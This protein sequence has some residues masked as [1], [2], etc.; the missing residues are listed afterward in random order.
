MLI[1][2]ASALKHCFLMYF[3]LQIIKVFGTH[4]LPVKAVP[5]YNQVPA[6]LSFDR[7]NK[8]YALNL[9]VQ[10][11]FIPDQRSTLQFFPKHFPY[12]QYPLQKTLMSHVCTTVIPAFPCFV[13]SCSDLTRNK[14]CLKKKKGG[15][16]RKLNIQQLLR[17]FSGF[18][19]SHSSSK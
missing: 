15:G 11:I 17:N 19:H 6:P 13:G 14:V 12:F 5:C 2:L 10:G 3:F 8:L 16:G 7:L 9:P 1:C 4:F 18:Q